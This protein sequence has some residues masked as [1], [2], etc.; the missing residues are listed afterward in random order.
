MAIDDPQEK[1]EDNENLGTSLVQ[2]FLRA[3]VSDIAAEAA[4][5]ALDSVLNEGLL[6]EV[7]VFGWIKKSYNVV[8]AVRDRLFLKKVANFLLG[9]QSISNDE[10]EIFLGKLNNDAA[11]S[12][13]VGESLVLLIDRQDNFEKSL[14]LGKLFS[15]YVRGYIEYEM[16]LKLAKAVEIAFVDDLR[17]LEKYYASIDA[18]DSKQ[19]RPFSDW[20]DDEVSQSLYT[21]GLIR[22]EGFT[23]NTFHSNS[24]GEELLRCLKE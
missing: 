21:S 10:R 18:Y 3:G 20:L 12:K 5:I 19:E 16:F 8:G 23:E 4:E 15:R 17:N 11:F 9:T 14:I 2:S 22:S 6:E 7:P 24:V 1:E 13:N